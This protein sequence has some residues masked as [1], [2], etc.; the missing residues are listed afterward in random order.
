MEAD[1]TLKRKKI[2][3]WTRQKAPFIYS[4][5]TGAASS[6][7]RIESLNLIIAGTE[8]NKNMIDE[9][10]VRKR[11][12]KT[13]V[14]TIIKIGIAATCKKNLITA[15]SGRDRAMIDKSAA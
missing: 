10:R 4:T 9:Q 6:G 5:K 8:I 2:I 3:S 11:V 14:V 12:F 1:I 7:P 15:I 13:H